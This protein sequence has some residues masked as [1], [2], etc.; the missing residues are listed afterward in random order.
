[1]GLGLLLRLKC[2][3]CR[4]QYETRLN[5][6]KPLCCFLIFISNSRWSPHFVTSFL[7]LKVV[8]LLYF[9]YSI[10]NFTALNLQGITSLHFLTTRVGLLLLLLI[11]LVSQ[12]TG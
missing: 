8:K 7:L 5:S 1:M 9:T 11:R 6:Y 3:G 2:V 10:V 12:T 4:G